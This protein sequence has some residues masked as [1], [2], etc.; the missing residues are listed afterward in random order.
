[1][2]AFHDFFF[3][4]LTAIVTFSSIAW[5]I[6]LINVPIAFPLSLRYNVAFYTAMFLPMT[7]VH[8]L[9][10]PQKGEYYVI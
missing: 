7:A 5:A 3:E 4:M 8:G 10:Y 2:G 1:M 9:F 6:R